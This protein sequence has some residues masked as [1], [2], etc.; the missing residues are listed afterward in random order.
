MKK[1]ELWIGLAIGAAIGAAATYVATSDKKEEWLEDL[2]HL[3][4]KVKDNVNKLTTKED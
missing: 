3:V 4:D 2:N 1:L